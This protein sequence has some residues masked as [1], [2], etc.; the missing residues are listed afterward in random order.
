MKLKTF[1]YI[2]LFFVFVISFQLLYHKQLGAI[3]FF[4]I[5]FVF[6]YLAYREWK[7][8]QETIIPYQK[9]GKD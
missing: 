1:L 8:S 4:L 3:S 6:F 2:I 7:E 5:S 9:E